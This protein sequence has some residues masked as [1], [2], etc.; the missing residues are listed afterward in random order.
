M[1]H[2]YD[3]MIAGP[4]A[5][6]VPARRRRRHGRPPRQAPARSH[7]MRRRLLVF[8]SVFLLSLAAALA[9]TFARPAVYQAS[10]RVQ[11]TPAA[12]LAPPEAANAAPRE[13]SQAFL[14][15]AQI[16]NSRPLLEEVVRR[17]Q[18][19]GALRH[20][21]GSPVLAVQD[22]LTVRPRPEAGV[23]EIAA[24]GPEPLVLSRMVNAVIDVYREQQERAG[25]AE[26]RKQLEEAREAARVIEQRVAERKRSVE[27]YRIRS[28]IV[29]AERDE[30]QALARLKGMNTALNSATERE[31]VA[32]GRLRAVEQAIAEGKAAPQARNNPTVASMEQR[33]SQWREEW[34]GLERRFTQQYLDMDPNTKALRMRIESLEQQLEAERRSGQQQA[35]ADARADVAS[36]KAA[37]EKLQQQLDSDKRGA[38]AFSQRL[39]EFKGMEDELQGLDRMRQAAQQKLV[40]L[41]ASAQARQPALLVVEA[42]ATPDA[43]VYP[44]YARD[45][46]ISLGAALALGFLAVWFVEFFNRPEPVPPSPSTVVVPQPWVPVPYAAGPGLAGPGP[47]LDALAH[48]PP[49]GSAAAAALLAR[50]QPRELQPRELQALLAAASPDNLGPL[51]FLLY[52]L[53]AEEL[54]SLRGGHVDRAAEALQVPG[55]A[56][57][58]LP[59]PQPLLALAGTPDAALAAAPLFPNAQGAALLAEDLASVVAATAYDA[60]LDQPET[61]TPEALRHTYIAYLVR[62]GLRFSELPRLV[63]RLPAE[64][65]NGL[66]PLAPTERVGA[67]AVQRVLPAVAGLAQA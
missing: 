43:P 50:A 3:R 60:Q 14:F 35:L 24:R 1:Q 59:L 67:D 61:V 10:A 32:Q 19:Q 20:I 44:H 51:A 8:F 64:T 37:S 36:A 5:E 52:G 21:D 27:A 66:A 16:L 12:R 18:E 33:L 25:R 28:E 48:P 6:E 15:E 2:T 22:M 30:N 55:A 17:L 40:A 63:G 9:Y 65:L 46:A 34:R 11:V 57:R 7:A 23:V 4:D 62:Q 47:A 49:P 38:Q 39:G 41:E 45:A 56:A 31:A 53:T 13:G 54:A 26:A 42:A 58:T 29:S